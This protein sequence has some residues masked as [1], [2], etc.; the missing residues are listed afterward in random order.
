MVYSVPGSS[1]TAGSSS[2]EKRERVSDGVATSWETPF[3]RNA[4]AVYLMT[5]DAVASIM[6][7]CATV[8]PHA[9]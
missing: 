6:R 2:T 8:A 9:T 4:L 3:W 7:M 5:H 1:P